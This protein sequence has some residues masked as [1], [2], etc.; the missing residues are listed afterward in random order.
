MH[1]QLSNPM[2]RTS[3]DRRIRGSHA[4]HNAERP[5]GTRRDRGQIIVI[6]VGGII[7]MFAMVGLIV[8]GGNAFANQRA[9]QNGTDAGALAGATQLAQ[10]LSAKGWTAVKSDA[11][12]AVAVGSSVAA[13]GLAGWAGYYTDVNGDMVDPSGNRENLT[14]KAAKVGSGVIP[15]CLDTTR[16]ASGHASGVRVLGNKTIGTFVAKLFGLNSIGIAADATARAGYVTHTCAAEAGCGVLPITFPNT[17]VSCDESGNAV[18]TNEPLVITDPPTRYIIPLCKN[19]PGNVGWLDWTPTAGGTSELIDSWLS[20]NNPAIPLPSWQY[21]PATGNINSQGLEDAMKT[22]IG[23]AG[24]MLTFDSTCD[25]EP[26]N[27]TLGSCP[28]DHVGGTGSNQWYHVPALSAFRVEEVYVSGSNP[29]CDTGNGATACIIG[30]FENFVTQGVVAAG[31]TT[32]TGAVGI[33]LI[34]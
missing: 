34:R 11:D 19:G 24:L 29:E 14:S 6:M 23:K 9:T 3:G 15:P 32:V 18:Q 26:A 25:V 28:D 16:C 20:P 22:Y 5:T 8:D 31:G 30:T 27:A 12:V 2:S 7:A 21:I 33:Q 4:M 10:N 13:N 17:M 1:R